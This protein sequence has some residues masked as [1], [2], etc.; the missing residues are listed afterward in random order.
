[1][2][3]CTWSYGMCDGRGT[4]SIFGWKKFPCFILKGITVE[5]L[6]FLRILIQ[7]SW[8]FSFVLHYLKFKSFPR[9][10]TMRAE[11]FNV[12][13][14][15]MNNSDLYRSFISLR[16]GFSRS[17]CTKFSFLYFDSAKKTT[18]DYLCKRFILIDICC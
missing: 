2:L 15:Q 7:F 11:K 12:C 17:I 6:L 8:R 1:M 5:Q 16:I 18:S 13:L 4:V 10:F 9:P 14:Q 3:Y